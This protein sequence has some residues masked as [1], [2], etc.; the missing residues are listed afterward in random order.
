MFSAQTSFFSP[1]RNY[2]NEVASERSSIISPNEEILY[3]VY[4]YVI[5][6]KNDTK[7]KRLKN[8][9]PARTRTRVTTTNILNRRI[10]Y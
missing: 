2:K 1:L 6:K 3:L 5:T 10:N 8:S 7:K 9:T 4:Y